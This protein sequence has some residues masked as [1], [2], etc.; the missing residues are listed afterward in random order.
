MKA[1]ILVLSMAV[2]M[3]SG[4]NF[5][6]VKANDNENLLSPGEKKTETVKVYGNCGMCKT[7][8]EKAA[9]AV[10]GVEKAE[11]DK[12]KKELTVTYNPEITN[13]ETIE[14]EVAAVGHDTDNVKATD[15]VYNDL[16]SCCKYDRPE[17]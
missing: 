16:H 3:L 6:T 11:W 7:R 10:D 13:I 4:L 15:E 17:K 8:I 5:S 12:E 14:K 1:K 9:N 2:M